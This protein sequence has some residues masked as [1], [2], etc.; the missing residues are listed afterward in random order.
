MPKL[1]QNI[2]A[3]IFDNFIGSVKTFR[4]IIG[5]VQGEDYIN[6]NGLICYLQNLTKTDFTQA[7]SKPKFIGLQKTN[8]IQSYSIEISY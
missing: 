6:M 3:E 2:S 7:L 8:N 1:I 5:Q 4:P